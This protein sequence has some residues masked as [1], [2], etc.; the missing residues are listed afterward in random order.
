M[1]KQKLIKAFHYII[2]AN[3]VFEILY[4]GYMVF[5]VLKMDGAGPGPL[6]ETVKVMDH[7]LFMKRRL[8]AIEFWI[9]FGGFAI[10]MALTDFRHYFSNNKAS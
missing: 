5:A 3:F 9:A 4:C 7:E 1:S 8:Y 6:F 2:I 10:Y